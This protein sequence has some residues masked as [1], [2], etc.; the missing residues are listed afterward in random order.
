MEEGERKALGL[1]YME[2]ACWKDKNCAV[3]VFW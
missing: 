3:T 1:L 2:A